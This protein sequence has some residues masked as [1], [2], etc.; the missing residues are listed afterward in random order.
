V[1]TVTA[2]PAIRLP[3]IAVKQS[4]PGVAYSVASSGGGGSFQAQ[5]FYGTRSGPG[6]WTVRNLNAGDEDDFEPQ[7]GAAAGNFH[8]VF[9]ET[10]GPPATPYSYVYQHEAP[11]PS[12]EFNLTGGATFSGGEAVPMRGDI[13]P[14][15]VRETVVINTQ[16]LKGSRWVRVDKKRTRS[17]AQGEWSFRHAALPVGATYRARAEV[18]DTVDHRAGKNPWVKFEVVGRRNH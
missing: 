16:R 2:G 12:I 11:R 4:T 1:Q 9:L 7:I 18:G 13:D 10:S 17:N 6:S 15:T 14:A 8:V 3:S 5:A